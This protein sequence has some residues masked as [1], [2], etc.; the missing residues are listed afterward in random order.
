MTLDDDDLPEMCLALIACY[1]AGERI[2][3]IR[4]GRG[5]YWRT[6][7]DRPDLSLEEARK[8]VDE[9][10]DTLDVK[11]DQQAEMVLRSMGQW[12]RSEG[13]EGTVH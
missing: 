6:E 11:A 10:N 9:L 5:G 4:R 3:A 7:Y 12:A 8:V 2:V 13:P 1:P